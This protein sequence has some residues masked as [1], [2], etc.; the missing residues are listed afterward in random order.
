MLKLQQLI[1]GMTGTI[2]VACLTP[3]GMLTEIMA[4]KEATK[5]EGYIFRPSFAVSKELTDFS[6]DDWLAMLA[7]YSVTYG[8][9][10]DFQD[11]MNL[12]PLDVLTGYQKKASFEVHLTPSLLEEPIKVVP[13]TFIK[14]FIKDILE[15][16][17][18]LRK[19]QIDCLKVCPTEILEEQF[20]SSNIIIKETEAIVAVVLVKRGS[21][22]DI[23]RDIDQIV[24]FLAYSYDL[25]GKLSRELLKNFNLRISTKN[26]KYLLDVIEGFD[27]QTTLQRMKKYTQFHKRLLKQ[28][29]WTTKAKM[30]ER[31]PKVM[32]IKY[33][34]YNR[35]TSTNATI[36]QKYQRNGDYRKAF[37]QETIDIGQL[38]RNILQYLRYSA[39]SIV[40]SKTNK[41]SSNIVVYDIRDSVCQKVF[42]RAL[43]K[44][45]K[46]LIHQVLLLIEEYQDKPEVYLRYVNNVTVEYAS[47]QPPLD[48][49]LVKIYKK[50]LKK[51]LKA[52]S[53]P[54]TGL[55]Y[56]DPVCKDYMIPFSGRNDSSQSTS[57]EYLA[58]GSKFQLPD[59]KGKLLRCGIMWRGNSTDLDL[60]LN[61]DKG[62]C[63]YGSPT[64]KCEGGT[65][66]ISSSGDITSSTWE[67]FSTELVDIDVGR[68]VKEGID[69]VV[70]SVISY[71]GSDLDSE[72]LEAYWFVE[73][74]EPEDRIIRDKKVTVTLEDTLYSI[75]LNSPNK[76]ALGIDFNLADGIATVLNSRV[77]RAL[78]SG[79]NSINLSDDFEEV[80]NNLPQTLSVYKALKLSIPKG[81]VT[82][83]KEEASV[84]FGPD[85]I[86]PGTNMPEVLKVVF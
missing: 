6:N 23:F 70:S 58:P 14:G 10:T 79:G 50:I 36:I 17:T 2:P 83:N 65:V 53:V 1:Y 32:E 44:A 71:S 39:G 62:V 47:P 41:N 63:Y 68:C 4:V 78:G 54:L 29:T 80:L 86:D 75:K 9:A 46:K 8:W 35:T 21:N 72:D 37:I 7:Q 60:S 76:A 28:L 77:P 67:S 56:I 22:I 20:M 26:R 42:K 59:S 27:V 69:R 55:V 85:G 66:I 15:S 24:R 12:S 81:Q 38:L 5:L 3:R 61:F 18:V 13:S 16:P 40:A 64:V 19:N 33:Q 52:L 45:N 25:D 43:K 30:L 73:L 34:L 49:L 11:M 84:I 57:G 74:I 48:L 31:Y 82:K 51:A